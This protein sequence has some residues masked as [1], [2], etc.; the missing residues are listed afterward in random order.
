LSA[1][2]GY[3]DEQF[4]SGFLLLRGDGITMNKSLAAHY[5]KMSA[6]QGLCSS[7]LAYANLLL[8]GDGVPINFEECERYLRLAVSQHSTVGQ[9][10]LGLCLFS[11]SLGHFDFAE[12]RELFDKAS[13]SDRFAA[14][15][16]DA[17]SLPNCELVDPLA[18]SR[19]GNLF[20]VLRCESTPAMSLIRVLNADLSEVPL[21]DDRRF[22]AW[23]QTAAYSLPYLVDLSR[24]D[25]YVLSSF[26]CDI[27]SCPSIS[28]MTQFVFRMYT[29]E[30]RLYTNVNHFLR[31]F[32]VSMVSKFMR[33]LN[34]ILSYISLLQSS[35]QYLSHTEPF[36][37]DLTVYRV[38]SGD[39]DLEL[40]YASM[41]GGVVVWPG[42]TSTS[43]DR[44]Y[45]LSTFATNDCCVLFEI[46]LH[47]GDIA[48]EIQDV[49]EYQD[50]REIL[51]PAS[52]AFEVMSVDDADD[53]IPSVRLR[54]FLD[55]CDF[56][57][58]DYPRAVI[59]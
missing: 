5:F 50:E 1:D 51:I 47:P 32:P 58:D 22:V 52:T 10:R 6:D 19:D 49:S 28:S 59:V 36:Q 39:G 31:Y 17:I 24:A 41:I 15:L 12:A 48:V 40:L 7:Q 16:R 37:E 3:V 53:S 46:E 11:G 55:W 44:N 42:F 2:Q 26:P 25:A 56:D 21:D 43:R 8:R 38:I 13:G 14:V 9:M 20:S 30:S 29:I 27:L 35:I 23:Q 4:Q 54:Y 33:D 18:F 57:L 34:G 45:V